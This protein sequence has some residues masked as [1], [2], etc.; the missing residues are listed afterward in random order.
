MHARPLASDDTAMLAAVVGWTFFLLVC[1]KL[2]K[3]L[4]PRHGHQCRGC[5]QLLRFGCCPPVLH[6]LCVVGISA[7][8]LSVQVCMMDAG[9]CGG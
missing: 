8:V 4:A 5:G 7:V 3:G 2:V 9:C 1:A 6:C